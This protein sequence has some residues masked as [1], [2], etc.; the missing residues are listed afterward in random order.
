LV[1][2]GSCSGDTEDGVELF[3]DVDRLRSNDQYDKIILRE[4]DQADRLFLFWSRRARRSKYVEKEWRYGLK[5]KGIDFIDP[6]PLTDPRRSP[7][8]PELGEKHFN[9]SILSFER[10]EKEFGWREWLINFLP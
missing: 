5:K 9:D 2:V 1:G 7:P 10:Y 8:P 4:I 6:V 3:L